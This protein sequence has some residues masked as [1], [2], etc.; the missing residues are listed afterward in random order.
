MR[1]TEGVQR[2]EDIVNLQPMELNE[3][4]D[5]ARRLWRVV[6]DTLLDGQRLKEPSS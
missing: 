1:L 6:L 3:S 5:I 4:R 2:V